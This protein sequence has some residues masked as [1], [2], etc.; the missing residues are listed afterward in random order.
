MESLSPFTLLSFCVIQ[1]E[2][3]C[4]HTPSLHKKKTLRTFLI[5]PPELI[6]K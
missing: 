6:V 1:H 5:L 2:S 3:V 4:L